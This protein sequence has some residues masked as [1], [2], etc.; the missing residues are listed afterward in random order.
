STSNMIHLVENTLGETERINE[1]AQHTR[2]VVERSSTKFQT[3]V[4]DFGVMTNQLGEITEAMQGLARTN[5][6][7][8]GKVTEIH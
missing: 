5:T 7:I 3:M 6:D 8:N 2:E 1:D 4:S